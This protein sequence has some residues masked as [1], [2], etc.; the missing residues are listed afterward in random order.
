MHE[1]AAQTPFPR[2][3]IWAKRVGLYAI[4]FV[5][6]M[7]VLV[8]LSFSVLGG[9][10]DNLQL[11]TDPVGLPNPWVFSNYTGL[12]TS[13]SFWRQVWNSTFIALMTVA[14]TLPAASLAAFV[15]ARYRFRGRELVYGFFT[16]GLLFPVAMAILGLFTTLRG[17][18]LLNSSL[19]VILPQVAFGLPLSII[20][21]RPFFEAIPREL[22][23]ASEVDGCSPFRFYWSV[24]LPLSRPVLS[25]LAILAVVGSWNAFFLPLLILIDDP[26]H[27]L[28]IGVNN[29]STQYSTDFALVLAYTTL[30]MLPAL[31]FYAIAERQIISG[32]TAG[33]VKA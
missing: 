29:V 26:T 6:A 18:G 17:L 4:A 1:V 24:M 8:P 30:A 14:L 7:G 5:V 9:F 3:T 27:T 21:M 31:V 22:Q 13:G 11:V 32:L 12:L 23:E 25:T 10:R 33:A 28:P 16:L 15:M 20:I 19:G 2:Q